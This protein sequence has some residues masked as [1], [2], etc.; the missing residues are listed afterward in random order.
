MKNQS[1]WIKSI[2]SI[3][4]VGFIFLASQNREVDR[5]SYSFTAN[6]VMDNYFSELAVVEQ[7]LLALEPRAGLVEKAEGDL[8]VFFMSY[9]DMLKKYIEEIEDNSDLSAL[10]K[11]SLIVYAKLI[12]ANQVHTPVYTINENSETVEKQNLAETAKRNAIAAQD[13]IAELMANNKLPLHS[14]SSTTEENYEDKLKSF[15]ITAYGENLFYAENLRPLGYFS[16]AHEAF[17]LFEEALRYDKNNLRAQMGYRAAYLPITDLTPTHL[18][19]SI[20]HLEKILSIRNLLTSTNPS[21]RIL[22]FNTYVWLVAAYTKKLDYERAR[23]YLTQAQ[24]MYPNS[25][26]L[27]VIKNLY[28]ER[29]NIFIGES[30][31][32]NADES[33][34]NFYYS[35]SIELKN[36]F[37][38][39]S[40]FNFIIN[41]VLLSPY[42]K[43]GASFYPFS[44]LAEEGLKTTYNGGYF[45]VGARQNPIFSGGVGLF[46]GLLDFGFTPGAGVI[47]LRLEYGQFFNYQSDASVA[48]GF[49][50]KNYHGI[51]PQFDVDLSLVHNHYNRLYMNHNLTYSY[52]FS[53]KVH[54]IDVS[55]KF[56]GV[57]YDHGFGE[58][59]F[60]PGVDFAYSSKPSLY[61]NR[62]DFFKRSPYSMGHFL[63]RLNYYE[64]QMD[65]VLLF[66]ASMGYRFYPLMFMD[67][68]T[69]AKGLFIA[70][71]FHLG[72]AV[73]NISTLDGDRSRKMEFG[74]SILGN[75]GYRFPGEKTISGGA[76]WNS[77]E[78]LVLNIMMH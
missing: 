25:G 38:F 39:A 29:R 10:E 13:E 56:P 41:P 12:L 68:Y 64:T 62:T 57:Y 60:T 78:G 42:L 3:L 54:L 47:L 58:F 51:S 23:F 37:L 7:E 43:I 30:S 71:S 72:G 32:G 36:S 22:V 48:S 1:I 2:T 26:Y 49:K 14:E 8:A 35:Y 75:I 67:D 63:A 52:S 4:L 55:I 59:F 40:Y 15:L 53:D 21:D 69:A 18:G 45:S 16:F 34:V 65:G 19:N 70:P 17:S 28:E 77:K 11:Q 66:H 74:Y 76:G 44:L 33:S 31:T 6:P 50:L 20:Y 24:T 61:L 9:E 27:R 5:S 46:T 73:R